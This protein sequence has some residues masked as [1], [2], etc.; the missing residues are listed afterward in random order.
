MTHACLNQSPVRSGSRAEYTAS[1]NLI[2]IVSFPS[3]RK[4]SF[5]SNCGAPG[6]GKLAN[7]DSIARGMCHR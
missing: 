1:L 5:D 4:L 3:G 7:S 2:E 6:E